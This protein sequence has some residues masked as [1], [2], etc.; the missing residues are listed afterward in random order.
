MKP[1]KKITILCGREV[2]LEMAWY[3][4][5]TFQSKENEKNSYCH[6]MTLQC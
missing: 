6:C 2:P 1:R 5:K 4:E 3:G